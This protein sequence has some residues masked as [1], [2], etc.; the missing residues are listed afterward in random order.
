[1]G[2]TSKVAGGCDDAAAQS[3]T[4]ERPLR[5]DA[6]RNRDPDP[7]G[8]RGRLRRRG[9]RGTGRR[10]RREGRRRRGDALPPLP[11]QGEALRGHP[12]RATGGRSPLDAQALADAEDPASAFFG[13]LAHVVAEG[14]AKRDLL[15]AVM[16]AGVAFEARRLRHQGRT[17]RRRRGALAPRSGHRSGA[18]GRHSLSRDGARGRD[19]P[20]GRARRRVV[21]RSAHIVCDGLRSSSLPTSPPAS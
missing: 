6:Q 2:P 3:A 19:L 18:T 20:G 8:G 21:E 17:P 13:F 14:A 1:M 9:N 10:H 5:A 15:V 16:G 4:A 7:R 12:P 11:D